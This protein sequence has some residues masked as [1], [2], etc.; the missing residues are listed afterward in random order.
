VRLAR[1]GRLGEVLRGRARSRYNRAL[2]RPG[3]FRLAGKVARPR[4]RPELSDGQ[5]VQQAVASVC[6]RGVQADELVH[7]THELGRLRLSRGR[8]M[9][10]L[11]GL[12]ESER[13]TQP[14]SAGALTDPTVVTPFGTRQAVSAVAW[15]DAKADLD[16]VRPVRTPENSL[17]VTSPPVVATAIASLYN[18]EDFIDGFLGN[19]TSQT[20]FPVCE[21]IIIDACSPGGEASRIAP[22][23]DRFE[24]IRYVR[25]DERI[26]IYEAWNLAIASA[27]GRYLTNTNLD[28]IRRADSFERQAAVLDSLPFVDIVYQDFYYSFDHDASFDEIAAVG[29]K[30]HSPVISAQGLLHCN[31]PGNGPMWRRTLHDELGLFREDFRSSSDYEFWLRCVRAGKTFYKLNDPHVGY[32]VN[33]QGMST[34][35]Q[36]PG[37]AE[38]RMISLEHGAGC[39]SEHLLSHDADFVEA[40][41][42]HAPSFDPPPLEPPQSARW[43]WDAAQRALRASSVEWRRS[44]GIA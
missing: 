7:M 17:S 10:D 21:L 38:S 8:L 42:L 25:T 39:L 18:G 22:Y 2:A 1:D 33:P 35:P 13:A 24:N 34:Q 44:R 23:L 30:T 11:R 20:I 43:R 16:T 29:V 36:T 19:I 32:F 5:F 4:L 31:Y 15:L 9:R 28:D 3:V 14:G 6:G 37:V 12:A 41:A 40:L 27:R 26:G